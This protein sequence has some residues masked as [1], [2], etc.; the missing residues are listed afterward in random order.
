MGEC[1]HQYFL[2]NGKVRKSGDFLHRFINEGNSIYE[3]TRLTGT[4]VMFLDDHIDRFFN[5]LKLDG[6]E[7]EFR[8]EE[9]RRQFSELIRLNPVQEGNIKFVHNTGTGGDRNFLVYFTVHRYPSEKDYL[10]GVKVI[11]F[12]FERVDPNKKIWRPAF[13]TDVAG[14][15]KENFAWEALLVDPNGFMPEASRSNLFALKDGGIITSPDE[16]I[17]SGITRKYVLR[18]CHEIGLPVEYRL[19]HRNEIEDMDA[20]FL[21][22]TSLQLLGIMQV[23][24][25]IIPLND[26]TVSRIRKEFENIKLRHIRETKKPA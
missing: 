22:S 25:Q 15:I 1:I 23:D 21:T 20:L 24:E 8:R 14:R 10:E 9:I 16:Y 18:A 5:S 4:G 12:P 11:T 26:S 2:L 13:R 17:L 19:I 3:V 7:P 6:L